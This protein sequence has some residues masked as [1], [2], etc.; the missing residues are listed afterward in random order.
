MNADQLQAYKDGMTRAAKL[1]EELCVEAWA[2]Y[3]SGNGPE[4]ADPH[5]QGI[6]SGAEMVA[7]KIEAERDSLRP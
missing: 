3:K 4:R 5:W 6:S 2:K 1:A 7:M